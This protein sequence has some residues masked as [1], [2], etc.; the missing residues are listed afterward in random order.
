MKRLHIELICLFLPALACAADSASVDRMAW[1]AGCWE[2]RAGEEYIQ[3][4]WMT[5]EG[6]TML[7]MGRTVVAGATREFEYMRIEENDGRLVFTALPSGQKVTSFTAIII[8]P[9]RIVF[10]NPTHD[11][12]QRVIYAHGDDG[13]LQAR[14][15]GE[16]DGKAQGVDFTMQRAACPAGG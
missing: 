5:P 11:F 9:S 15:E 4:Q 14:I 10:E 1:L 12:P 16:M 8:T 13:S 7:G 6:G 2:R 3:E